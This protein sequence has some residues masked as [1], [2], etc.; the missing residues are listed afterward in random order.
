MTRKLPLFGPSSGLVSEP[1]FGPAY[2][3]GVYLHWPYCARICPYCDFN[4]YAAKARDTAPL[5]AAMLHDLEAQARALPDHPP[6][7]SLFF[8]GG[9]PSLMTAPQI[10]RVITTCQTLFGLAPNCEITLEANPNNVTRQR[11][12]DWRAAGINRLSI[13]LQS[14]DD[15]ALS[16]LGRDHNS[17]HAR[18][19]AEIAHAHFASFS[20]DMI[21]ARPGQSLADWDRELS[22]ALALGAPHLSLY[23]LTIAPGTAFAKAVD[24]GTLCPLPDE[25]Q[26]QMY[27]R[28]E[29]LTAAAGL[30]A[31]EISNHASSAE[32]AS[33]H[34]MIYWQ[35]G[36][37]IGLGPG[38]HGRLT[39]N[40]A[41]I[42]TEAHAR[43]DAYIKSA[44]GV[45]GQAPVWRTQETL[46]QEGA[47]HELV[48]MGL[49]PVSGMALWRVERALGRP[50]NPET[51]A[52]LRA[53]G[54]LAD[55]AQTLALTPAG[56]LLAD[57]V[58]LELLS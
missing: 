16:F 57:R 41:R 17:A 2:G 35:S 26:A 48:T 4:V 49:R 9:T 23:E 27:E 22:A 39:I 51:L 36:D 11:A 3:F 19:A 38:A 58:A 32:H 8:G 56:R 24:R 42:S 44:A 15:D 28:T 53:G 40:G 34:N 6:L 14:L 54:W 12:Q 45:D 1:A 10:E 13:G 52:H 5:L 30:P 46:T 33:A 31:Y 25:M 47:A 7:T 43:P 50:I 29:A 21:Y 55:T 18:D 37:W 20:I